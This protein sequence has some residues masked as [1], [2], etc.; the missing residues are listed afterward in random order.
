VRVERRGY[1]GRACVVALDDACGAVL[2]GDLHARSDAV[3]AAAFI[4]GGA[5]RAR[6]SRVVSARAPARSSCNR[7]L[8]YI[9][10]PG[11][12]RGVYGKLMLHGCSARGGAVEISIWR[13][14]VVT[15][16][17]MRMAK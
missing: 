7:A 16:L 17:G 8:S 9:A 5:E 4:G 6:V 12:R 3:Q 2:D 1:D 15:I 11:L 10:T 14:E 13:D